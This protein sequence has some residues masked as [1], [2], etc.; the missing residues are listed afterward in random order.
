MLDRIQPSVDALIEHVEE[1]TGYQAPAPVVLE[2]GSETEGG[3]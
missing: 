3:G 2:H 1:R